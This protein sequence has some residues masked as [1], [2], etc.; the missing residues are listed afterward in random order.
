MRIDEIT[1][2]MKVK[3][4]NAM[5]DN[6]WVDNSVLEIIRLQ[7]SAMA[8]CRKTIL[9]SESYSNRKA[10]MVI[11]ANLSDHETRHE[12][13]ICIIT[14]SSSGV[15]TLTPDFNFRRA[16]YTFRYRGKIY[17]YKLI[18]CEQFTDIDCIIREEATFKK[19]LDTYRTYLQSLV[20]TTFHRVPT[21]NKL[22]LLNGTIQSA[23]SLN[24]NPIFVYYQLYLPIGWHAEMDDVHSGFTQTSNLRKKLAVFGYPIEFNVTSNNDCSG[25][26]HKQSPCLMFK[27][28]SIDRW[29]CVKIEGYG[30]WTIPLLSGS[31]L[32]DVNCWRLY[33]RKEELT[34][35][36]F[37][38]TIDLKDLRY[39]VEFDSERGINSRFGLCTTSAC[40]I[41]LTMNVLVQNSCNAGEFESTEEKSGTIDNCIGNARSRLKDLIDAFD[42]AKSEI[43]SAQRDAKRILENN[44]LK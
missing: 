10:F 31:Y 33:K 2:C 12:E 35:Q 44:L 18:H 25:D 39:L 27:V 43:K 40:R 23:T 3:S 7:T 37:G 38:S 29:K 14:Y 28:F 6:Q 8:D 26:I 15:L 41:N 21:G 19:K 16:C 42:K 30:S 17:S 20:S 22:I 9:L 1:Y 4:I 34:F 24:K 32:T 11:M 13:I 36:L 5:I